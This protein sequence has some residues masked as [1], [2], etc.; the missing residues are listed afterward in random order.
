M[1]QAL[2]MKQPDSLCVVEQQID[3]LALSVSK[4]CPALKSGQGKVPSSWNTGRDILETALCAA[5]IPT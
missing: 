4:L 5:V 1:S 3:S 2:V